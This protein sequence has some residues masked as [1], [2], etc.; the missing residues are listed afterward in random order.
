MIED[1]VLIIKPNCL[2]VDKAIIFFKLYSKFAPNPVINIV[3]LEINNQ[4]KVS[5]YYI[6]C[7][8]ARA[9]ACANA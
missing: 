7:V 3:K 9:R 2:S 8:G 5:H 6:V 1:K 4:N